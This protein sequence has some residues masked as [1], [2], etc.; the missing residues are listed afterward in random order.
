MTTNTTKQ[1]EADQ[2]KAAIAACAL[3]IKGICLTKPNAEWTPLIEQR[4]NFMLTQIARATQASEVE[5]AQ[6]AIALNNKQILNICKMYDVF[7]DYDIEFIYLSHSIIMEN[8]RARKSFADSQP[9][10]QVTE[11]D[12]KNFHRLLCERFGYVHDEQDWRRDQLSLIEH[13]VAST[14]KAS[15][16]EQAPVAYTTHADLELIKKHNTATLYKEP[17]Q[18]DI[19]LYTAYTAATA[20]P[21]A[22]QDK[23]DAE[24]YRWLKAWDKTDGWSDAQIDRQIGIDAALA[25]TAQSDKGD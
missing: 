2:H 24:R 12:F 10:E 20:A 23:R 8:E 7:A 18:G 4:I 16:V 22:E 1:A 6:T 5:Q 11:S 21:T 9:S 17:L 15:E 19:P 14:A 3:M 13:I 25:A